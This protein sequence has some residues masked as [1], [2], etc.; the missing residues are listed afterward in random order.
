MFLPMRPS[1]KDHDRVLNAVTVVIA[2]V[3]F[4]GIALSRHGFAAETD[5][6]RFS[7]PDLLTFDKV[8]EDVGS[9]VRIRVRAALTCTECTENRSRTGLDRV[10]G[11]WFFTTDLLDSNQEI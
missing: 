3:L 4:L 5:Y 9:T 10:S 11:E 1:S 6:I 8:K 7:K 2:V